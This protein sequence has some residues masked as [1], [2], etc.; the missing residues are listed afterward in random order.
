M[1]GNREA[2]LMS[3]ER[4]RTVYGRRADYKSVPYLAGGLAL[5]I[6]SSGMKGFGIF[7]AIAGDPLVGVGLIAGAYA[8]GHVSDRAFDRGKAI[9]SHG[10]AVESRI[11]Q[12]RGGS[13]AL[14]MRGVVPGRPR[15]AGMMRLGGPMPA[16]TA[17]AGA[18]SRRIL[19]GI[20]KLVLG[21]PTVAAGV[22]ESATRMHV[23]G[24]PTVAA[25]V[26]LIVSGMRDITGGKAGTSAP[27]PN[28]GTAKG[29]AKIMAG[30][31][32]FITGAVESLLGV[33]TLGVPTMLSGAGLVISGMR[34]IAGSRRGVPAAGAFRN[35]SAAAANHEI[36]HPQRRYAAAAPGP[37][38]QYKDSWQDSRGRQYT[39][40]DF[41]VRTA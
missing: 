22:V 19:K 14:G 17:P 1:G 24:V 23:L 40:Q 13:A 41:S 2:E 18:D 20:G 21:A 7:N 3:S 10:R 11:S 27:A 8:V 16:A 33:H 5:G 15:P 9:R 28:P 29:M 30:A 31:P 6:A 36:E 35:A 26:G 25:G 4:Q 12:A 39:R 37:R 34:D 38:S 32:T